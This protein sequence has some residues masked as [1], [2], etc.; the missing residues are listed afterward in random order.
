MD[1]NPS[2]DRLDRESARA[3]TAR[4]WVRA[5]LTTCLA[6]TFVTLC[7]FPYLQW[8]KHPS[9]FH[10]DFMRAGSLRNSSLGEALFR[11][12]NEHMAPLFETVSYL[13]WLGAG[14]Q[15]QVLPTAF[16]VASFVSFAA[17][18]AML[19]ALIRR[20][21]GSM[22]SSL[23][24]VAFFCLSSVSA[25]TVLWYSASSFQWAAASTLAAW[26]CAAAAAGFTSQRGEKFWLVASALASLAAPAFSAIGIMAAPVAGLRLLAV[27]GRPFLTARRLVRAAIPVS[28]LATYLLICA[29]FRYREV[30]TDSLSK[31][32]DLGTALWTTARAPAWAL[33]P[34]LLGM[35]DQS[36]T[37]PGVLAAVVT[38]VVL[39][40]SLV[41]SARSR[42]RPLILGGIALIVG[43][44]LLT[45]AARAHPGEFWIIKISRYH[46]FPQIGLICLIVAPLGRFVA[47]LDARPGRSLLAATLVASILAPL[48][49]RGMRL[50]AEASFRFPDQARL[51]AAE[52]RL[53]EVAG[54]EAIGF[55]QLMRALDPAQPRWAPHPWPFHPILFLFP[56]GSSEGRIMPDSAAR[57]AII[58]GLTPEEREVLFG[59]MDVTRHL[60]P[61]PPPDGREPSTAG[62][63]V[64]TSRISRLGE[65]LYEALDAPAYLEY[66]VDPSADDARTL[67]L[68]GLKT[69]WP[70]EIWWT[71]STEPWS[72]D[73]SVRWN[74][75]PEAMRGDLA[76]PIDALPHWR[77][78]AARRLRIVYGVSGPLA[79]GDPRF[80]R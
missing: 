24:A 35:P 34:A 40:G 67:S 47:R 19:A 75:V 31:N 8:L 43:G 55:D 12:F 33:F 44:Y 38:G 9:L 11:P 65:G 14:R 68:P 72:P 64:A 3:T 10:D 61:A 63:L 22:T 59:G 51:L 32:L 29:G 71:G 26:Y 78:G 66:Q 27:G 18:I 62:R 13:A 17:T 6:A 45:Y 50:A 21:T 20:E 73:R 2:P 70:I 77:R 57:A 1:H 69:D 5:A 52:A 41:A 74:P 54:L 7:G 53:E 37:I 60:R 36:M 46:L 15:I 16:M 48:Q 28:G 79:V 58:A 80:L 76:V 39:V 25:E 56:Q 30:L 49:Y 4:P 42:L 23:V